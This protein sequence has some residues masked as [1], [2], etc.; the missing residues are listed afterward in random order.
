MGKT[1]RAVIVYGNDTHLHIQMYR[2]DKAQGKYV[3]FDMT[4]VSDLVVYLICSKHSTNINLDYT[5]NDAYHNIIDCFI[6]FTFS[7]RL[8]HIK[9][10]V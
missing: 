2:F 10:V 9:L 7:L 5:I 3:D 4:E 6:D 8:S 1:D